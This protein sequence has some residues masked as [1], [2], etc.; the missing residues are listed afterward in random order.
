MLLTAVARHKNVRGL[1]KSPNYGGCSGERLEGC[2]LKC[3]G[4]VDSGARVP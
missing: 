3:G 4:K 1:S 2:G